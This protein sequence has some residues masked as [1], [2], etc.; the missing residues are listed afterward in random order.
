MNIAYILP[1]LAKQAPIMIAT[2]IA[3]TLAQKG[4]DVTIFYFSGDIQVSLDAS[5]TVNKISFFKKINLNKVDV[6]HSH[7]LRPDLF[8]FFQSFISNSNTK[9]KL[10]TTLHNYVY[11]ELKNYYNGLVSILFGSI[12]NLCWVKFDRLVVLT[13][14]A[15][16]YYEKYSFNKNIC[17]IY[18]G[19]NV[20]YDLLCDAE[21]LALREM[22][23]QRGLTIIG[24]YCNLIKRKNI[25]FLIDFVDKYNDFSLIV[26]GD[27]PEFENLNSKVK[28][29]G[30]QERVF[31]M[32]YKENAYIYNNIFDIYAIPSV[33]EGFGLALIEAALYKKKIVCSDIPVFKEIFDENAVSFFSTSDLDSLFLAINDIK[34]KTCSEEYAYHY[35]KGNYSIEKMAVEYLNVYKKVCGTHHE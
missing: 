13:D 24:T 32:G 25:S 27:G 17:R 6:V 20:N 14:D 9:T 35:A 26:Y 12:W 4:H 33:D 5:I 29:R 8:L 16:K 2:S 7:L 30:L 31:L 19:H 1:S 15:K 28:E 34:N 21:S 11:P 22:L 10:I 3:N 23:K 18:N